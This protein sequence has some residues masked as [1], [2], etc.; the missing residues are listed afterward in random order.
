MASWS[1]V[2][3]AAPDLAASVQAR[4]QATGLGLL[5][6]LRKDGSPRLS[7]IEPLFA[8][9][10]LWLGMMPDSLKAADLQRDG[11][12]ALHSAT[13]DKEVKEGDAKL[14]GVAH[15]VL[16]DATKSAYQAGFKEQNG[17]DIPPGAFALFRLDVRELSFL[18]PV[19]GEYLEITVW[20]EG[21]DVRRIERR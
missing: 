2:T 11:R 16:D 3:A 18:R 9:G 6:T 15:E 14:A 21:E 19:G 7:G 5:A 20:R 13:A 12:F 10:E 4:F 17:Q 1:A 8:M